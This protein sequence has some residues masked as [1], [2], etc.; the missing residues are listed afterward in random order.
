MHDFTLYGLDDED[1]VLAIESLQA[2]RVDDARRIARAR[3]A[4]FPRVELWSAAVC[5]YRSRNRTRPAP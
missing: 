2:E 3:L 1:R 5:V 4:R